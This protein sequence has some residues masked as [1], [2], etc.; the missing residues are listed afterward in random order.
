[1]WLGRQATL[2][3]TPSQCC[4]CSACRPVLPVLLRR[5][6]LPTAPP[7]RRPQEKRSGTFCCGGCGQPLYASSTKYESGAQRCCSYFSLAC[8]AILPGA[9][10][11]LGGWRARCPSRAPLPAA[12]QPLASSRACPN[13]CCSPPPPSPFA[14]QAPAG[15]PSLMHCLELW[16]LS[17][18]TQSPSCPASRCAA[19]AAAPAVGPRCCLVPGARLQGGGALQG[20]A[21]PD[22][23]A[24]LAQGASCQHR[25]ACIMPP[26]HTPSPPT[27]R[28]CAARAAWATWG[29]SSR[30]GR[31]P[32]TAATA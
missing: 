5:S 18:I 1:M 23:R 28:R 14:A 10:A 30:T 32:P 20:W 9:A 25:C 17:P 7:L 15:L 3:T 29:M 22:G 27:P 13:Q 19:A 2:A 4:A 12:G 26:R 8:G 16:R 6:R 31:R 11:R 21:E 24:R